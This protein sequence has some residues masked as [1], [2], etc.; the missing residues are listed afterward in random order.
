MIRITSGYYVEVMR[1]L[2]PV[3]WICFKTKK[4]AIAFYDKL[5]EAEQNI[6]TAEYWYSKPHKIERAITTRFGYHS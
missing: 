5:P 6:E 4:A 1:S 2:E 3:S